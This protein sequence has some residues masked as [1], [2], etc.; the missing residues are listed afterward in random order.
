MD[1]KDGIKTTTIKRTLF[2]VDPTKDPTNPA[3]YKLKPFCKDTLLNKKELDYDTFW[4]DVPEF[5]DIK[6][7][8]KLRQDQTRGTVDEVGWKK[9]SNNIFKFNFGV[10]NYVMENYVKLTLQMRNIT[11]KNTTEI[12]GYYEAAIEVEK[13]LKANSLCDDLVDLDK[14]LA[15]SCNV[16]HWANYYIRQKDED[17]LEYEAYKACIAAGHVWSK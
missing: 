6:K 2:A 13:Q 12:N 16:R 17:K 1:E 10:W 3:Y 15:G 9:D 7:S 11:D 4:K 8:S 5:E 14:T